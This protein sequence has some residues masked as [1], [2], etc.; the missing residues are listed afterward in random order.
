MY[1]YL[2]RIPL[3]RVLAQKFRPSFKES[4]SV[5]AEELEAALWRKHE[6][7][8]PDRSQAYPSCENIE[9]GLTFWP[10]ELTACC[11]TWGQNEGKPRL[12]EFA[13]GEIPLKE[14]LRSRSVI[15]SENQGRGY[16]GCRGCPRLVVRKWPARAY[17]FH[18]VVLCHFTTCNVRCKYCYLV[19]SPEL[20]SPRS[21]PVLP[22]FETFLDR[23]LL[24]PDA[25]VS[26]SDGEPTILPE[27][28]D[29]VR[30][31]LPEV[32]AVWVFSNGIVF[33][34][35]V[36]EGLRSG[37]VGPL[38]LG[39]DAGSPEVYRALKDR[40]YCDRV[41]S[42]AAR[43]AAAGKGVVA[44]M[45]LRDENFGDTENFAARTRDAG[46]DTVFFDVD[47][48]GLRTYK[49]AAV[50]AAARLKV[51]CRER[52]VSAS[53]WNSPNHFPELSSKIEQRMNEISRSGASDSPK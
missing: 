1:G 36:E 12:A 3:V 42:N 9:G 27:F 6:L 8:P 14:I 31:I 49:E 25:T 10:K 20:A 24:S 43:Y 34:E 4:D 39:V 46:I 2:Q 32:G 19:R 5:N 48:G 21:Y 53:L 33:S 26:F 16:E 11:F 50:D 22:I 23:R 47:W 30:R 51:A 13:G 28:E 45:V 52:G 41:W 7:E 15:I 18:H 44:K 35:A 40:D 37:V 17:A 38:V 29:L